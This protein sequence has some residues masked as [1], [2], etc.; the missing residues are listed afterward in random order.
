MLNVSITESINLSSVLITEVECWGSLS[1][2]TAYSPSGAL[3]TT[4]YDVRNG[5]ERFFWDFGVESVG[6][7]F[8]ANCYDIVCPINVIELDDT[9]KLQV[10]QEMYPNDD[11]QVEYYMSLKSD[12][13]RYNFVPE[14]YVGQGASQTSPVSS[15]VSPSSPVFDLFASPSTSPKVCRDSIR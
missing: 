5:D 3:Y 12:A 8:E 15:P 11:D 2:I 6:A 13:D 10:L 4:D 9:K 14:E 1:N 7:F